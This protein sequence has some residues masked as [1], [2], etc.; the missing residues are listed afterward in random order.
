MLTD[1][2]SG[3]GSLV[4]NYIE[5]SQSSNLYDEQK[6]ITRSL[7]QYNSID[8]FIEAHWRTLIGDSTMSG[9]FPVPTEFGRRFDIL[10][11]QMEFRA[12]NKNKNEMGIIPWHRL[13]TIIEECYTG[14]SRAE[15]IGR[16]A[17]LRNESHEVYELE[18]IRGH[19]EDDIDE[20]DRETR[21]AVEGLESNTSEEH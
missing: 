9:R 15:W 12:G 6:E 8:G 21:F 11:I 10:H 18:T 7:P 1:L 5:L 17:S 16:L 14:S 3:K 13:V 20:V 19:S 4:T 2:Y